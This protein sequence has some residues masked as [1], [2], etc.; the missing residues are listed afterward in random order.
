M[1]IDEA[2]RRDEPTLLGVA[3][4]VGEDA[5]SRASGGAPCPVGGPCPRGQQVEQGHP[6]G[7]AV[8]DLRL[9]ERARAVRDRRRDL[10][11]FVHRP[12][13]EDR[14]VGPH[15]RDARLAEPPRVRVLA[16]RRQESG[17][18]P[19]LLEAQRD[20]GV[21][22]VERAVE[23]RL[24]RRAARGHPA[25]PRRGDERRRPGQRDRRAER[26][27]RVDIR[28]GHARVRDVADDHDPLPGEIAERVA[29]R[30]RVEQALGRVRV[31]AVAGVDDRGIG[32]L[33]DEVRR[34]RR[35]VA[36][37]D[38]VATERRERAYG[39]EQRLA[40]LD[41]RSA[42]GDVRD[43]RGQRLRRE[44]ERDARAGRGFGEEQDDRAAAQ[45]RRAADRAA[46]DLDHRAGRLEHLLDLVARPVV[47]REDVS[48]LPGHAATPAGTSST[49][50]LPPIST[51]CTR[52]SS[53][54]AVGTF[55]P[56]KSARIGS[57][58]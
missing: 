30:V 58:R 56:T 50:S 8:G 23:I 21:R 24:V 18:L 45:R 14:R 4:D 9:D 44:L 37:D 40:L 2:R 49:S 10:D 13:V 32:P 5:H 19:L 53:V 1:Q 46:E 51:S 27:E 54:I 20:H 43:I 3:P 41:R 38:D 12:R 48:P 33:R 11:A 22:A 57:S 6:D 34:A 16:D 7:D 55:L 17:V 42:R 52:T 36:H 47:R 31:P 35:G 29:Q 28:A 39:V 26:H 15:P 25:A